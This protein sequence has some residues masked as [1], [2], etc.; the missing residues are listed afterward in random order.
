MTD[1]IPERA[2]DVVAGMYVIDV[3][4]L[5]AATVWAGRVPTARYGTVEVRPIVDD[6][7]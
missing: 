2:G 7:G 4:D 3:S 1:G 5:D 6:A